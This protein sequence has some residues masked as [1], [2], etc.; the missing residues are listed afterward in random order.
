MAKKHDESKD[1]LRVS[2]VCS[3]SHYDKIIRINDKSRLVLKHG[4]N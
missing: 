2:R 1:L 4:K 3:V